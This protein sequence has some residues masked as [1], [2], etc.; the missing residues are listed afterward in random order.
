VWRKWATAYA[1]KQFVPNANLSTYSH[2]GVGFAAVSFDQA[3]EAVF[4]NLKVWIL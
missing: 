1:N 2:G 3:T 4:R